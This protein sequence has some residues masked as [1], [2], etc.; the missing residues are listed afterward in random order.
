MALIHHLIQSLLLAMRLASRYREQFVVARRLSVGTL[1]L[2]GHGK[3]WL[4]TAIGRKGVERKKRA[5]STRQAS[6]WRLTSRD[7]CSILE[8][9]M[10]R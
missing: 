10:K 3:V 1:Q 6:A 2:S 5:K 7:W 8:H 9:Y 4:P